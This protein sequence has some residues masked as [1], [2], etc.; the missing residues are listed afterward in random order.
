MDFTS[1]SIDYIILLFSILVASFPG[2]ANSHPGSSGLALGVHLVADGSR[3]PSSSALTGGVLLEITTSS[4]VPVTRR[5]AV[6]IRCVQMCPTLLEFLQ[7]TATIVRSNVYR[8]MPTLLLSH[9]SLL[10]PCLF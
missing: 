3:R 7:T 5:V 2:I 1:P 10:H 6:Q 4:A 9:F 8:S